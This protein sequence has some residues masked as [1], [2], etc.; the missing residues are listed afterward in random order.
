MA[1]MSV[2]KVL[3]V[4]D[5]MSL[6]TLYQQYLRNEKVEILTAGNGA[7]AKY[8]VANQEPSLVL[9]DLGL[10]DIKGMDLLEWIKSEYPHIEV[11]I[12]T[13]Q[14]AIDTVVEVMRLGALDFIE[15]PFD[16]KRLI[17]TVKN[18]LKQIALSQQLETLQNTF[19]RSEY[20]GFIGSSLPMQAIYKIIEAAAPSRATVFIT[21]ESG[22]GKEVCARAI[23]RQS[24]RQAGP[25]IALNCGAIPRELMESEIFGHVKG[26]FTGAQ[27]ARDGVATQADGGTLFLDEIAEMDMDLQTK[28]LRF[29][30]TGK[31]QPVGSDKEISVDIRFVCATNKNPLDEVKAGRFREDLYYRLQVIPIHL[32]RLA[33][34]GED[35]LAIA[36]YFL[37]QFATEENKAFA[38]LSEEVKQL[39]LDYDWPGNVRQL[40]NV[41]QNIVVLHNAK[42]VESQHLP[43]PLNSIAVS[44]EATSP[45]AE[46]PT[47]QVV[48]SSA[49]KIQPL[50]VTEREAIES[51]IAHCN[52]NIPKAAELLD[53]S[54]ST[55]YRK[56]VSWD[57]AG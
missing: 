50:A 5:S 39:F 26:A 12:I 55:I 49:V 23:H 54:P 15:K 4:E 29:L 34:R 47:P 38:G 10:P 41:I 28:L 7:E 17:T 11:V 21:G 42:L 57:S 8:L 40:Q 16:G 13:S 20:Q 35:T 22:T 33:E 32:P 24:P 3:I 48:A 9:L 36:D 6:N 30:Q 2:K 44:M 45:A 46:P 1:S 43:H 51:A 25:F 52:G 14:N 56:K 19:A 27:K 31:F 37:K 53:V 18:A